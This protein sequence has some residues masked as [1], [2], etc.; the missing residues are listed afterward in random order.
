MELR[1][2]ETFK[3]MKA[4]AEEKANNGENVSFAFHIEGQVYSLYNGAVLESTYDPIM[5]F[6]VN[7]PI[8][9]YYVF[10]G[11]SDADKYIAPFDDDSIASA[12]VG[13]KLYGTLIRHNNCKLFPVGNTGYPYGFKTDYGKYPYSYSGFPYYTNVPPVTNSVEY[14]SLFDMQIEHNKEALKGKGVL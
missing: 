6:G 8:E 3:D 13:Y 12:L 9:V 1:Y 10:R 14:K 2:F 11:S 4:W 5:E 7:S